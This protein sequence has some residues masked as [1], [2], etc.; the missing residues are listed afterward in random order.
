MSPV[1]TPIRRHIATLSASGAKVFDLASERL[2]VCD[3]TSCSKDAWCT[4]RTLVCQVGSTVELDIQYT[5]EHDQAEPYTVPLMPSK[6]LYASVMVQPV[7]N[8]GMCQVTVP[9][10]GPTGDEAHYLGLL[11]DDE[12]RGAIRLMLF[13]WF[14]SE[15]PNFYGCKIQSHSRI[16]GQRWLSHVE[17]SKRDKPNAEAVEAEILAGMF[18]V[19]TTGVCSHCRALMDTQND[20]PVV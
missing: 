19:L 8:H 13:E 18:D 15:W 20:V 1:S 9:L 10:D 14:R 6:N 4:H 16:G 5:R 17:H 11:A 3:L 7:H 12:G 2:I